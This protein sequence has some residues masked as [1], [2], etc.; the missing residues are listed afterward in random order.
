MKQ[1]QENNQK[2]VNAPVQNSIPS[3]KRKIDE[4]SGSH[5]THPQNIRSK[6]RKLTLQSPDQQVISNVANSKL[7]DTSFNDLPWDVVRLILNYIQPVL[8]RSFRV[9]K[10]LTKLINKRKKGLHFRNGEVSSKVFFSLAEKSRTIKSF[11]IS[12]NLKFIKKTEID[13]FKDCLLFSQL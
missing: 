2:Q 8:L 10:E 1:I 6:V 5:N 12:V 4:I 7:Y 13:K 9:N 3:K 11:Q